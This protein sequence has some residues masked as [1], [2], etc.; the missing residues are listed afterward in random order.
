MAI[1]DPPGPATKAVLNLVAV[2]LL[3][4]LLFFWGGGVKLN[5]AYI[6][7]PFYNFD[8]QYIYIYQMSNLYHQTSNIYQTSDIRHSFGHLRRS[9][10][11]PMS[12]IT[13]HVN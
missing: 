6:C 2:V 9:I 8:V 5:L 1:G 11:Y 3:L 10:V 7:Q 4:L 12:T 13:V